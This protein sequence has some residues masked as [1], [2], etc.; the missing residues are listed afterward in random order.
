MKVIKI[1]AFLI[2]LVLIAQSFLT[3]CPTCYHNTELIIHDDQTG[4]MENFDQEE[5]VEDFDTLLEQ[6]YKEIR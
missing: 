2:G 3:A 5:E 6:E 1:V 4:E